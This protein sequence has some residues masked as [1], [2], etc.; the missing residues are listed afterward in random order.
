MKLSDRMR[1][2]VRRRAGQVVLR[3]E[4][5]G[6]GSTSQVTHALKALQRDGELIRLGAGVF[7]KA[8]KDAETGAVRPLAAFEALA[9]EA[10]VKLKMVPESKSGGVAGTAKSLRGGSDSLVLDTGRR[11]V[12]RK[13]TLGGRTVA[14]VNDRTRRRSDE[15]SLGG[16]LTIP[17]TGVAQFVRDLA[18]QFGVSYARTPSDQWAETVT[19]LAGDE[20]RSRARLVGRAEAGWQALH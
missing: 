7:A 18:R 15:A 10:A 2:S 9:R 14:Y 5:E 3:S 1:L 12:S 4:L 8:H 20:V 19:R 6:L 13:L 17:T 16:R 11:R